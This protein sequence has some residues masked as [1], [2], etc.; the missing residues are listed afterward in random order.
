M[1][2]GPNLRMRQATPAGVTGDTGPAM[3]VR[4]PTRPQPGPGQSFLDERLPTNPPLVAGT[5]GQELFE[6]EVADH[7]I[8][9]Y[10]R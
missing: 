5:R 8:N 10:G 6:A 4:S 1:L 9:I 7:E 3:S 2:P